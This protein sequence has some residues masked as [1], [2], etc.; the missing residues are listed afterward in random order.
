MDVSRAGL[1]ERLERFDRRQ[2]I[3]ALVV[4]SGECP[5]RLE[6]QRRDHQQKQPGVQRYVA[7]DPG[8]LY[9]AE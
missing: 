2:R 4:R 7:G 8:N 5:H 6:V 9:V 3:G 1:E